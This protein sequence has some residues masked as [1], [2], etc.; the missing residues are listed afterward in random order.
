MHIGQLVKVNYGG[1]EMD[2]VIKAEM[3]N[4]RYQVV[5]DGICVEVYHR[6]QITAV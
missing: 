3:D 2:A 5:I 4:N 6:S 1:V